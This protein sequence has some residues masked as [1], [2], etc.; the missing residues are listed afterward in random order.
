MLRTWILLKFL[1][2]VAR[3][4]ILVVRFAGISTGLIRLSQ[5][6]MNAGF[7]YEGVSFSVFARQLPGTVPL[8]RCVVRGSAYHFTSNDG[9]CEGQQQEGAYGFVSQQPRREASRAIYRCVRGADHL[10]TVNPQE[11][12]AAGYRVEGGQGYAQ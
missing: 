8:F 6:G 7:Q 11:C 1:E 3:Q 2:Q 9:N 12:N 4:F 5:E 10:T